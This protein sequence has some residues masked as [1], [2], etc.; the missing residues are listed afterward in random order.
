MICFE[1]DKEEKGFVGI[2]RRKTKRKNGVEILEQE[3]MAYG[4]P[5]EHRECLEGGAEA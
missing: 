4:K 5:Q 2:R 1:C 3:G